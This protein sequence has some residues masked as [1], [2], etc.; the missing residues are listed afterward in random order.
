MHREHR[1]GL[2]AERRN[3]QILHFSSLQQKED[4]MVFDMPRASRTGFISPSTRPRSPPPPFSS[5]NNSPAH[6]SSPSY[7]K[8]PRPDDD[9]RRE[10]E[11]ASL[12]EV[13]RAT[14]GSGLH[15]TG[16]QI[17]DQDKSK[18]FYTQVLGM[19]VI[20]ETENG[21]ATM[22]WLAFPN[23]ADGEDP[24][25]EFGQRRGMLQLVHVTGS[26]SQKGFRIVHGVPGFCHFCVNVTDLSA[27]MARYKTMGVNIVE[28]GDNEQGWGAIS[29]PDGYTIQLL[30]CKIDQSRAL[31]RQV[32]EMMSIASSSDNRRSAS[33]ERAGSAVPSSLSTLDRSG[34]NTSRGG[35]S[36][37]HSGLPG[38]NSFRGGSPDFE[39]PHWQ[40]EQD[41]QAQYAGHHL[42]PTTSTTDASD[43]DD[44]FVPGPRSRRPSH[45]H[46]DDSLPAMMANMMNGGSDGEFGQASS[47]SR[48]PPSPLTPAATRSGSLSAPLSSQASNMS[49]SRS[50]SIFRP[51]APKSIDLTAL[52]KEAQNEFTPDGTSVDAG[53]AGTAASGP[54]SASPSASGSKSAAGGPS[55]LRQALSSATVRQSISPPTAGGGANGKHK[56]KASGIVGSGSGDKRQSV[57]NPVSSS[58][59]SKARILGHGSSSGGKSGSNSATR[60]EDLPAKAKSKAHSGLKSFR[61]RFSFGVGGGG[62][63]H[64]H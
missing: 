53:E 35:G 1:A 60:N 20:K 27:S 25:L 24:D 4:I 32:E 52:Q 44:H 49:R 47:S 28:E 62:D 3:N 11:L 39:H 6:G 50:G 33:R 55:S 17:K 57:S 9:F 14:F 5:H 7:S 59:N 16:I 37:V 8:T 61:D 51:N 41:Q 64:H 43:E 30:Y 45:A 21:N 42:A 38:L 26:E 18:W 46:G 29:D 54:S 40:M 58:S 15:S 56:K 34:T 63:H 23:P 10:A 36:S 12:V 48:R 22:I 2:Q 19:D 31:K 13:R